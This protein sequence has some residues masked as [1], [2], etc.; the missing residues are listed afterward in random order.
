[1]PFPATLA[2][3]EAAGYTRMVYTRCSGCGAAMEFWRT[4]GGK[5]IPMNPMSS[6]EAEAVSH[7]ATCTSA[8]K[9]RKPPHKEVAP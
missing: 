3:L 9:F 5:R 2:A 4:P 1:M 6:P 8:A 7:F